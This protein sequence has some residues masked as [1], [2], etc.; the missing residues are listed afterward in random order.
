MSDSPPT[1]A[2]VE[3]ADS[4]QTARPALRDAWQ[5]GLRAAYQN[6]LPGLVLWLFGLGILTGYWFLPSIQEM[7]ESIGRFKSQWGWRYSLISTA[8]CGGFVPGI[9]M[10]LTQM[11]S[12]KVTAGFVTANT[13]LWAYKGLEID[14]FY[15]LQ[16]IWFG[17]SATPQIITAKTIC[18]QLLMVPL[19]GIPNVVLFYLWRDCG[20]SF[21]RFRLALGKN[22]Y[23]RRI[24][25]VL[26]AN[27]MV[28]I[29]AVAMIYSLPAALQLPVQNLILC[30][31]VLILLVFTG[32]APGG[33][34][35]HSQS[36]KDN[37]ACRG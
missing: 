9:V 37:D 32:P 29:P 11:H 15:Q 34:N 17:T 14:F 20:Y 23:R 25:P 8:I 22:W 24:V 30:F 1:A 16:A 5:T 28:W 6:R 27:W 31:W 21:Q 19:I 13:L 26:I 4:I 3:V 10:R 18:D 36:A 33:D 7:F 35:L 2:L 12:Q